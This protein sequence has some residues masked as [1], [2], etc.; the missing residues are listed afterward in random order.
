MLSHFDVFCTIEK[1]VRT[2]AATGQGVAELFQ[3]VAEDLA[4]SLEAEG[5]S[6]GDELPAVAAHPEVR[7]RRYAVTPPPPHSA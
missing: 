1:V 5:T 3:M 6:G 7:L 2:S 4:G